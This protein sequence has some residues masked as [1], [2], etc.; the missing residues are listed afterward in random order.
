MLQGALDPQQYPLEK[1]K[2]SIFSSVT[3]NMVEAWFKPSSSSSS[4][5][6]IGSLQ[7]LIS[8][9]KSNSIKQL[10]IWQLTSIYYL[11]I[12]S[13]EI[14]KTTHYG[15]RSGRD[16]HPCLFVAPPKGAD[17]AGSLS[18]RCSSVVPSTVPVLR[19]K[20]GVNPQFPSR[21]GHFNW[22]NDG[23]PVASKHFL[24]ST[25]SFLTTLATL[26]E[27]NMAWRIPF[28]DD[29]PNYKPPNFACPSGI[30]SEKTLDHPPKRPAGASLEALLPAIQVTTAVHSPNDLCAKAGAMVKLHVFYMD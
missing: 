2:P 15:D 10:E 5:L 9:T 1:Q 29:F 6:I 12:K 4:C 22:E 7:P 30:P 8:I 23:K 11:F 13:L 25:K 16:W 28:V 24:K 27:S 21:D 14:V 3:M 20:N 17:S 19:S 18:M 26:R